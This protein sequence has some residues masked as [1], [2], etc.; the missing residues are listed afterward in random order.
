MNYFPLAEK[1]VEVLQTKTQNSNPLFF[2]VITAYYFSM[3]AGAN[4]SS[5]VEALHAYL[6]LYDKGL[7]RDKLVKSSS[8]NTRFE[9]IDGHTPSNLL[10][11]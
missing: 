7:I 4:L 9:R 5:S 11:I 1:L 8:E 6:E 10:I 2:R 3:V